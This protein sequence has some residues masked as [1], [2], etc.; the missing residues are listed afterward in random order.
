MGLVLRP[1]DNK[2]LS[3]SKKKFV[4]HEECYAKFDN[5]NGTNPLAHF[6]IPMIDLDNTKAE[7]ENLEKISDYKKK[8][9]IPDHVLSV[10]ALSDLQKH[11]ELNV[12][13]PPT[14]PPKVIFKDIVD[15]I[16]PQKKGENQRENQGEKTT[17]HVPEHAVFNKDL[18]L[19]KLKELIESINQRYDN[20]G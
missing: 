13:N 4:V 12:A 6:V 10:K 17:T 3:V 1:E 16:E 7:V 15:I 2:I 19:D 5:A 11:P 14:N 18:W 8:Y 9:N 20:E